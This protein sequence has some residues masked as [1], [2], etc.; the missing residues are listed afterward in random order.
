MLRLNSLLRTDPFW[1][2]TNLRPLV[3][4]FWEFCYLVL[5]EEPDDLPSLWSLAVLLM[6]VSI[7]G[8]AEGFALF[9]GATGPRERERLLA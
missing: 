1:H 5:R 9:V 4:K 8:T 6:G 7:D 3:L 2:I